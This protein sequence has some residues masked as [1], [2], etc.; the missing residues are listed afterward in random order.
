MFERTGEYCGSRVL[1]PQYSPVV[2]RNTKEYSKL[3]TIFMISLRPTEMREMVM[4]F[5]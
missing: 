2:G 1:Q 5:V 4:F 3:L